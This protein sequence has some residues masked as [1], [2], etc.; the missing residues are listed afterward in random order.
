[1]KSGALSPAIIGKDGVEKILEIP[2]SADEKG[3][4]EKSAKSVQSVVD[5]C[6][7]S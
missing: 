4:L 5:V 2:L 1:M 7:K 6:K 3:M